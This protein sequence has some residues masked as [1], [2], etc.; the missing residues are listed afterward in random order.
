MK[1][2]RVKSEVYQVPTHRE[3]H[4]AVRHFNKLGLVLANVE[5]DE[6]VSG[7]G[8]TYTVNLHG[9]L[10]IGSI[11][12][13]SISDLV[14]GMDPNDHERVWYRTCRSWQPSPMVCSLNTFQS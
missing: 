7:T 4:D 6:G 2:T 12:S 14:R 13:R 8:F 11:I 1:I 3:I 5:T 10:E 9:A